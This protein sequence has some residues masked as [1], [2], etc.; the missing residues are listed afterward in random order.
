MKIYKNP[1]RSFGDVGRTYGAKINGALLQILVPKAVTKKTHKE[2]M[3]EFNEKK[4]VVEGR[5][6]VV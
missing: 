3:S 1:F 6:V 4:I 5:S 2:P